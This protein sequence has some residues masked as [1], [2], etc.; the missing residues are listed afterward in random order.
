MRIH[1]ITSICLALVAG[2]GALLSGGCTDAELEPLAQPRL[3]RDDKLRATGEFCTTSPESV[4]FPLRVL[5]VVDSSESMLVTDPG[6]PVSQETGR[7]R[8]V[9]ET[10]ETVLEGKPEGVKVG[11]IRFSAEAHSETPTDLDV[12]ADGLAD[13]YFTTDSVVLQTGTLGLRTTDRTT[14]YLN[15]LSEAYFE[16]RTEFKAADLE[17]LP[18]SKYVVIFLSDGLPDVDNREALQNT[19]ENILDAVKQVKD[20]AELYHVGSF[21]FHTAYLTSGNGMAYDQQAQ[22]LLQRMAE[23]GEG[24]FR[25][26][27]SGESLNFLHVDFTSARRVFTLKGMSAVNQNALVNRNQILKYLSPKPSA[28]AGTDG[29]TDAGAVRDSGSTDGGK[30]ATTD[31]GHT[32]HDASAVDQRLFTDLDDNQL[33]GCSEPLV[34]SDGDGLSDLTELAIKTDRF[35]SDTD[36]DGLGDGLEWKMASSGFDPTDPAD[37]RCFIPDPCVDQNSDGFC[38]CVRDVD[39]NGQCDCTVDTERPCQDTLGHDC[40]DKNRDG[41]CDC[42]DYDGDGRCDYTDRDRDALDDCEELYLGTARNG[43]DSDADGLPDWLEVHAESNPVSDDRLTDLDWDQTPDGAEVLSGTDPWCNESA[44]RSLVSYQYQVEKIRSKEGTTCYSFDIGNIT[45]VPTAT[46]PR[47]DYPGNGWNRLLFFI[48][49]VS[50]DDPDAFPLYRVACVMAR[51]EPDGNYRNPPSGR[52]SL[53][54]SDF[55]STAQF[56]PE[57]HCIWPKG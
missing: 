45:L 29:G 11:I 39:M 35:V 55:V 49:E 26:F 1:V 15:A 41:L 36:N 42:P 51:Y 48:G 20:L 32:E 52:V 10:W 56:R 17:S 40:V 21:Q 8:A 33:P 4:V 25:S 31:A 24:S 7:E 27:P 38:D 2:R 13:S 6:D 5:F 43:Y 34:D 54:E 18:L 16:L 44:I 50:F 23:M 3:V 19:E 57:I 47:G 46:N 9:R 28:D 22:N 12:P 53:K 37:A 14:N 30:K